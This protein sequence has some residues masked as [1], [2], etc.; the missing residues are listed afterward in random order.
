VCKVNDFEIGFYG[1]KI[2]YFSLCFEFI[3]L[4]IRFYLDWMKVHRLL[5]HFS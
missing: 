5:L 2:M 3:L 1:A 4:P